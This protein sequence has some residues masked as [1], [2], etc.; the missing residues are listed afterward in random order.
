MPVTRSVHEN[1]RGRLA[2]LGK[3]FSCSLGQLFDEWSLVVVALG[4]EFKRGY[5]SGARVASFR[6]NLER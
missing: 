3:I 2:R 4:T 1:E 6:R 5:D